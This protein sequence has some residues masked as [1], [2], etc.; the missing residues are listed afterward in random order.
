MLTAERLGVKCADCLYVGNGGSDELIG[1]YRSAMYP[2][3][4]LPEENAESY[5]IPSDEVK[6]FAQR[7]GTI[8]SSLE[9]VL[10]L[11]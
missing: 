10:S 4:I 8:V 5:L 11:V 7:H 3:L 9:E 2:V 6:D 1:A